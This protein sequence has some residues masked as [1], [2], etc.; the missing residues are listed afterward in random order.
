MYPRITLNIETQGQL[1]ANQG[2]LENLG[3]TELRRHVE[4]ARIRDEKRKLIEQLH[5]YADENNRSDWI[6][7]LKPSKNGTFPSNSRRA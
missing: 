2:S 3:L 6:M 1:G 7:N 4:E 5:F